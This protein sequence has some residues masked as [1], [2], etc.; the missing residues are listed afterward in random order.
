MGDAACTC[1][2][3]TGGGDEVEK[4]VLSGSAVKVSETL[5]ALLEVLGER[6]NACSI[7][8]ERRLT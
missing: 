3:T 1:P 6:S 8:L 2:G 7:I 4:V 5:E